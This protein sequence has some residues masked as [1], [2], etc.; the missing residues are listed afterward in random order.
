M[1]E[2][3]SVKNVNKKFATQY[4]GLGK[5][6]T[7]VC[8]KDSYVQQSFKEECDINTIM[9]KWQK[10][11]LDAFAD[12]LN[13]GQY[14][15]ALNAIDYHTA[16]QAVIEADNMFM[17]MPSSVRSF[18][19]NDPAKFIE[20]AEDPKNLPKM[21]ELGLAH[22]TSLPEDSSKPEKSTEKASESESKEVS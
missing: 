1:A 20:F 3:L 5:R 10:T 13:S 14:V 11:G 15:N 6:P 21:V 2:T 22:E 12:R 4:N 17:D 16:V 8:P 9:K 19:D 18:F 7:V